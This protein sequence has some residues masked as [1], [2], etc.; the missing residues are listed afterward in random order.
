MNC[1]GTQLLEDYGDNTDEVYVQYHGFVA[2]WINEE[3]PG[4]CSVV[5]LIW[6]IF[7]M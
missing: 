3:L 4:V 2:P 5:M 7:R 1:I 6:Y